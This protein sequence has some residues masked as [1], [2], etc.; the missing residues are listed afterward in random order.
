MLLVLFVLLC[1]SRL[2]NVHV[3]STGAQALKK[4]KYGS[5]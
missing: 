3:S 5:H 4:L 2:I 1:Q